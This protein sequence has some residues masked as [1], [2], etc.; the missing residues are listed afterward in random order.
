MELTD[1]TLAGPNLRKTYGIAT[2]RWTFRNI[3]LSKAT[4]QIY[5]LSVGRSEPHLATYT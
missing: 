5:A 2:F 4:K 1:P 3:L